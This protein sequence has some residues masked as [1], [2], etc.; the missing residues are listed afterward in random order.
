MK[1]KNEG[2]KSYILKINSKAFYMPCAGHNLNLV[3]GDM[4]KCNSHAISFFGT[5]QRI[6]TIFAASTKRWDVLREQVPYLSVKPLS[7]IRWECRV[8]SVKAI[9][10]QMKEIINALFELIEISDESK[11]ISEAEGLIQQMET[12]DFTVLTVILYDLL[13]A[14]NIV[15]KYLQSEDMQLDIAV[16]N[17]KGLL[18]FLNNYRDSGFV[19]AIISAKEIAEIIDIEPEFKIKRM[20]R[21]KKTI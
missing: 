14:V 5:I 16:K 18:K 20:R 7:E 15:S 13:H 17:L 19:S 3:L 8:D 12:F 9:R 11:I 1:G 10:Y 6:Y 4:A 21:K 2:V